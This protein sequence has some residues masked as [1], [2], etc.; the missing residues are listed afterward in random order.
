MKSSEFLEILNQN[1]C[2][3]QTTEY[4][5]K[6]TR[7]NANNRKN[8]NN[9][10]QES[11]TQPRTTKQERKQ[12]NNLNKSKQ[13]KQ[14]P[15]QP[16]TTETSKNIPQQTKNNLNNP[17]HADTIYN[18]ENNLTKPSNVTQPKTNT[19]CNNSQQPETTLNSLKPI[20]TN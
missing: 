10:N 16:K 8:Q 7:T 3:T 5:G 17:Q 4:F 13:H 9:L 2:H 15:R 6:Q 14:Q 12:P 20:A 1:T 18:N 19:S 11:I